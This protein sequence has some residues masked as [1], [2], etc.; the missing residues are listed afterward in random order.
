MIK[1]EQPRLDE[2]DISQDAPYMRAMIA[3]RYEQLWRAAAPGFTNPDDNPDWRPDPRHIEA[4]IRILRNLS[5]LYRLDM[6]AGSPAEAVSGI[7]V[8]VRE[9]VA[10]M[11]DSLESRM[12]ESA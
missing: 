2:E 1:A 10:G 4:G 3:A 5:G 6:P 12:R 9:L 8:G 7:Q 11:L